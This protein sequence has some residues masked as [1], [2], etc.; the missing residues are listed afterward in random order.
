M[1]ANVKRTGLLGIAAAA[2]LLLSAACATT[3]TGDGSDPNLLTPE[4]IAEVNASSLYEVVN[5][6]R[7]RW[8]EVRSSRSFEAETSVVVFQNE[9]LLGGTETLRRYGPE[10][11]YSLRYMDGEA[12]SASLSG[13]GSRHV[14][15]AI[16]IRTGGGG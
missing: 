15:G 4:E 8:L 10:A 7:P 16:I 2:M 13:L 5:R 12:A 3:S 11:G 14:E 9:T 6:L 1:H